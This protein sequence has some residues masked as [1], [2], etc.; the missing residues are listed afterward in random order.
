MKNSAWITGIMAFLGASI[1]PLIYDLLKNYVIPS[2]QQKA[3]RRFKNIMQPLDD[4]M[5]HMGHYEHILLNLW[6]H[7]RDSQKLEFERWYR[8]Y[9]NVGRKIVRSA[10]KLESALEQA[11]IPLR[12]HASP[13]FK[14]LVDTSSD[15]RRQYARNAYEFGNI[16]EKSSG[17]V[18]SEEQAEQY[19]IECCETHK[20]IGEAFQTFAKEFSAQFSLLAMLGR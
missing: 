1:G 8:D 6:Q 15:I 18:C 17:P 14:L 11:N 3:Y 20:R 5:M 12:L 10:H 9:V 2:P 13:I 19:W 4:I 7:T 16:V